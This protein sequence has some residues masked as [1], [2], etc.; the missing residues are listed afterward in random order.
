M[1]EYPEWMKVCHAGLCEKSQKNLAELNEVINLYL[2]ERMKGKTDSPE[3]YKRAKALL[4]DALRVKLGLAELKVAM[5]SEEIK[6]A[7]A[8]TPGPDLFQ[9]VEIPDTLPDQL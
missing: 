5:I 7:E 3:L 2:V 9:G 4:L 1:T 6:Q 8:K